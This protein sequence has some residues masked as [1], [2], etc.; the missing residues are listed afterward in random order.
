MRLLV[1]LRGEL[2]DAEQCVP[3]FLQGD[4]FT[5]GA[6]LMPSPSGV[7][8]HV[9]SAQKK[10]VSRSQWATEQHGRIK[11]LLD[12]HKTRDLRYSHRGSQNDRDNP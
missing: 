9:K 4:S 3:V 7:L 6:A 1:S 10:Y 12:T 2:Q 8:R 5:Q 11:S